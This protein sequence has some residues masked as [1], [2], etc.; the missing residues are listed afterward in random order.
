MLV[1]PCPS[2]SSV[3]ANLLGEFRLGVVCQLTFALALALRVLILL[4][5]FRLGVVY[6]NP[7]PSLSSGC[8]ILPHLLGEFRRVYVNCTT[9]SLQVAFYNNGH[10]A[11]P[12]WHMWVHGMYMLC[13]RESTHALYTPVI[14]MLHVLWNLLRCFDAF[15]RVPFEVPSFQG[16][17]NTY[18]WV[19]TKV[20]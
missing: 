11:L 14:V 7:C 1:N 16:C 12:L 13:G 2:L 10:G 3:C 9:E 4:G 17:F 18:Y 5:E 8:A 6:L 19:P 20:S 15:N